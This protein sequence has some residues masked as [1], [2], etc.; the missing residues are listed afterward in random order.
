MSLMVFGWILIA[1]SFIFFVVYAALD[2]GTAGCFFLSIG[3]LAFL[4]GMGCIIAAMFISYDAW[5]M[6]KLFFQ[7]I[8]AQII[9]II[10]SVVGILLFFAILYLYFKITGQE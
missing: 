1:L 3:A 10:I 5:E 7:L 9:S 2:S 6:I 4:S 8:A